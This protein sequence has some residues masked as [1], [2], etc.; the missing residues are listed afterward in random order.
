M[1]MLYAIR[2]KTYTVCRL[3]STEMSKAYIKQ[4]P[5]FYHTVCHQYWQNSTRALILLE[6]SALYKLFTYLRNKS[7]GLIDG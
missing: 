7:I 1:M 5:P 2:Y 6:T 3:R 4:K